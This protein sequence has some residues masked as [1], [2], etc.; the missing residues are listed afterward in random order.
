MEWQKKNTG[1]KIGTE[2][3]TDTEPKTVP[4]QTVGGKPEQEAKQNTENSK[5][6]G[7]KS[8]PSQKICDIMEK[9][10][11]AVQK[12]NWILQQIEGQRKVEDELRLKMVEEQKLLEERGRSIEEGMQRNLQL[13]RYN[14]QRR[15]ELDAQVYGFYGISE[16]KRDGMKQYRSALFKGCAVIL[17]VLSFAMTLVSAYLYGPLE[18]ITIAMA[19]CV[20]AEG[21]L[22]PGRGKR[23]SFLQGVCNFFYV[24]VFPGMIYLFVGYEFKFLEYDWI[25]LGVTCAVM[26]FSLIGCISYFAY[27]PY[28][29]DKYGVRQAKKELK[30][31]H[32]KAEKQVQKNQKIRIKEEKEAEKTARKEEEREKKKQSKEKKRALRKEKSF[33][34]KEEARKRKFGNNK[35]ELLLAGGENALENMEEPEAVAAMNTGVI[36]DHEV[37]ME[38][39]SEATQKGEETVVSEQTKEQ[40]ANIRKQDPENPEQKK[41]ETAEIKR[42]NQKNSEQKKDETEEVNLQGD[43]IPEKESG[44]DKEEEKELSAN[45]ISSEETDLEAA[46]EQWESEL[47]QVNVS[48]SKLRKWRLIK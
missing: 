1:T 45:E 20:A 27:N 41:K 18:K 28:K 23:S 4:E 47:A 8:C 37:I 44:S 48:G 40:T 35:V 11:M 2:G 29:K 26:L 14:E 24:A 39:V 17:F 19:G 16:D 9:E 36:E 34:R 6:S 43:E 3:I 21:A 13:R 22:M 46:T 31:L 30:Q 12:S 5:E 25:L 32:R 33:K 42:H 38:G 7:T 10:S 15:E